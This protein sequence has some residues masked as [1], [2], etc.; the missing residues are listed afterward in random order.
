MMTAVGHLETHGY[1]T[2]LHS[3][4]GEQYILLTPDLLVNLAASIMLLADKNPRELGAVS[5]TEL[6]QG[7]YPFDELKGLD[8]PEQQI[9]LDAAILRFLRAQHL[10]PRDAG[11]RH[12]AHLPQS[13]QAKTSP[14]R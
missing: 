9:L 11:Q 8:K 5:E 13:H 1:V 2:V 10:L 14:A 7:K 4:A 12:P 6:L 3:S